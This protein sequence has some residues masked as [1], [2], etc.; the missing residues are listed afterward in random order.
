MRV[1]HIVPS[2]EERH[3]GPSK[4]VL[5][6]ARAQRGAGLVTEVCATAPTAP[7][8][9]EDGVRIFARDRPERLCR[10]IGLAAHLQASS[11][12]IIHHHSLWLLTVR[13]AAGAAKR[14]GAPLV[15]SPRGMLSEWA[16]SHHRWRKKL[17]DRLVH[18]GAFT[19][20]RGWHATSAEEADD[21]RRLGWKQPI[22]IAP[23]GVDLPGPAELDAAR[24]HWHEAY[25]VLRDRRVALFYSRFHRKKRLHELLDL[26]VSAPR[27]DWVLL[28]AGLPQE[29]SLREVRGWIDAS[30]AR[31]GVV[32]ADSTG[33]PAPYAAAQL[34]L[35]P[36]HS[37]NFGLVIAEALAAGLPA[38]VTDATP[39]RG[40]PSHNAGW[41]VQWDRYGDSLR[42]A[43]STPQASLAAMGEAGRAWMAAEY[44]W[45]RA[46]QLTADFYR[47]LRANRST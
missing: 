45:S 31:E 3:G 13:Y 19:V 15:I 11:A 44:S 38:L 29:Y 18:P 30:G 22:C 35:L 40:L 5:A 39:W 41:C 27:G 25:P 20:A 43:L 4:S 23:N 2:L 47:S 28:L 17:A 24:R 21:I 16:L 6:L 9:N 46:G 33:H 37:E 7:V 26:W 1:C 14:T 8:G 42:A 34:F 12:D 32:V 10:S 36:S